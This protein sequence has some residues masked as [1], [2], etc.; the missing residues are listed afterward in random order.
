MSCPPQQIAD[1]PSLENQRPANPSLKKFL[2]ALLLFLSGC[3]YHLENQSIKKSIEVP[4]I[5]GDPSGEFT[6]KLIYLL[7]SSGCYRT[8]GAS[9]RYCLSVSIIGSKDQNVGFKYDR[10][11]EGR[12][13]TTLIPSESRWSILAEVNLVDKSTGK[14]VLG[15]AR[16]SASYDFDHDWY[17]TMDGINIFSLGQITDY[18]DAKDQV[19]TPLYHK[20]AQ[21]ITDLLIQW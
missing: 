16:V 11:N 10:N 8:G 13:L 1:V 15:P 17:S 21:K 3:G 14:I 18:A 6:T 7:N 5:C 9:S 2:I 4:F 20:L 12:L 19:Q